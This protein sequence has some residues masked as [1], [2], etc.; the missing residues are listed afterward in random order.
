[1]T[2]SAVC[3]DEDDNKTLLARALQRHCLREATRRR[4]ES[5]ARGSDVRICHE[6]AG[7]APPVPLT[8]LSVMGGTGR[9]CN[10][11]TAAGVKRVADV[12]YVTAQKRLA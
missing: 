4:C 5:G 1:M 7:K 2:K 6:Q 12:R 3:A 11:T 8:G 9:G 10:A